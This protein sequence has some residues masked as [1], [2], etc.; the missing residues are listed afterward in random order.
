MV[1]LSEPLDRR[2]HLIA[3]PQ[4]D[5]WILSHADACGSSGENDVA[6]LQAHELADIG[7]SLRTREVHVGATTA[8]ALD[9][10]DAELQRQAPRVGDLVARE[11]PWSKRRERIRALAFEALPAPIELKLTLGEVDAD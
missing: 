5:L 9:P 8:R 6:G 3:G 1:L 2:A 4:I 11:E 7:P 10:V